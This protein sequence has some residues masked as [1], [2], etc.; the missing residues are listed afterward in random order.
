VL[1]VIKIRHLPGVNS[2]REEEEEEEKGGGSKSI[3]LAPHRHLFAKELRR[4]F[5]S[6]DSATVPLELSATQ[7][8]V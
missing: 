1:K 2:H 7:D 4:N 3:V 5:V 8:R 6:Q